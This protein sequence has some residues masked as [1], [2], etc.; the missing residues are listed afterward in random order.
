MN[1]LVFALGAQ[2]PNSLP[3]Q[4]GSWAPRAKKPGTTFQLDPWAAWFLT[5]RDAFDI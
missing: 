5:H 2:K 4:F 1:N 3:H